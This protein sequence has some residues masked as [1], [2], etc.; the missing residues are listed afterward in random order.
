MNT[1]RI[2]PAEAE[3]FSKRPI[4]PITH[5][6]VSAFCSSVAERN[7]AKAAKSCLDLLTK[8]GVE[9]L[10]SSVGDE[11]AAQSMTLFAAG[12][13]NMLADPE[14]KLSET[15][16]RAF[17]VN[18]HSLRRV[19]L[20]TS[21]KDM[22]HLFSLIANG[23]SD[24]KA[25]VS[26]S[27]LW[28]LMII[29]SIDNLQESFFQVL[30][31]TKPELQTLL[32]ASLLDIKFLV[33]DDEQSN[34]DRLIGMTDKIKVS[35]CRS[36]AE[37]DLFH[38]VW[39]RCSYWDNPNR[40]Q[41]K[42]F[43]NTVFYEGAKIRG[44]EL[45][46]AKQFK[47]AENAKPKLL[48][49]H[50]AWTK[51]HAMYRCYAKAYESL[52]KKFQ[53]TA[54]VE[55]AR[56]QISA[57]KMFDEV[58]FFS[59]VGDLK[60]TVTQIERSEPD[61]I[62][63]SSLGMHPQNNFLAQL[64]LAPIQL[65]TLGHPASSFS[66]MIDYVIVEEEASGALGRL[67]EKVLL[68]EDGTFSMA[69]PPQIA[70]ASVVEKPASYETGI[71]KIVCNSVVHKITPRFI[72]TCATIQKSTEKEL[73]WIFLAGTDALSYR[74][75]NPHIQSKLTNAA[76]QMKL[77]YQEYSRLIAE[78]DL[79]LTPFPFGNTNS[80]IDAMMLGV[81]TVCMDGDELM[82]HSDVIYGRR[83]GL[84]DFLQTSSV[85]E[86]VEAALR[87]INDHSLRASV[88][89]NIL[90]TNMDELFFDRNCKKEDDLSHLLAW[91]YSNHKSVSKSG[92]KVWS[93]SDRG[94]F[95]DE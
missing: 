8:I 21:F 63:F 18:K 20:A 61:V 16:L 1:D 85:D 23:Q 79:Q 28:R 47:P 74:A 30:E 44:V 48:V 90:N 15:G 65:M 71:I 88:R 51:S 43:L 27:D 31:N 92:K 26:S 41:V 12:I 57:T 49:V 62:L 32:W 86:Y 75:M 42:R 14:L 6:E 56:T 22:S 53:V 84:P 55:K 91:I 35:P 59:E 76:V 7:H 37:A 45:N 93:V 9:G 60:E 40:H 58:I 19:F 80:F 13:T 70:V 34:L 2:N 73:E 5:E 29:M 54:L 50:E 52:P 39:F 3:R 11:Q 33:S 82:S 36:V 10:I 67:H 89:E 77:P 25:S 66:D 17:L 95:L 4:R 83:V 94:K 69:K 24:G 87:L 46:S 81:P 68:L 38:R 72:E 78:C 64:R